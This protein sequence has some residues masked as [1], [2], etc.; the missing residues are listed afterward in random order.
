MLLKNTSHAMVNKTRV[1]KEGSV[2]KK[3]N[4]Y[5]LNSGTVKVCPY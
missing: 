4:G 2:A 1:E 5:T 3:T